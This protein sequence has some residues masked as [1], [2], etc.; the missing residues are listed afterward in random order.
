MISIEKALATV[1]ASVKP[2]K[3]ER[4]EIAESLDRVLAEDIVA[5]DD[6]PPFSN[7]AMD[8]YAVKAADLK[9]ASRRSP[10]RLPV[11]EDIPAGRVGSLRIENGR[12]ARIMTGAPVPPGADAVVRVEETREA[13]GGAVEIS[14]PVRK[15]ENIRRA[16]ENVKK[17]E[18]V[19]KKGWTIRPQEIGMLAALGY[20]SVRVIR[21][22]RVA[23]ISTGDE[24]QA[25]TEKP[26]VGKIRD[27]NRYTLTALVARY[28]GIP[29]PLGIVPDREREL[30]AKFKKALACDLFVTSGGVSVGKYDF[31]KKVMGEICS[32]VKVWQVAM[33]PGK[34]LS[35]GLMK[36]KPV[37]GLP[38]NPVSVMVS[39]LQF[40]RPALLKM[41]GKKK[42]RKPNVRATLSKD[43]R[44]KTDRTHLVRAIVKKVGGKYYARPSGPQGSGILRSLVLANAL[45]IIPPNRGPVRKG[46]R[47]RAILIDEAEE[48]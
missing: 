38:G 25:I 37:F 34:P 3:S 26:V 27:C 9:S 20:S 29:V 12:A 7:S 31:V 43:C 28:G 46:E 14:A 1:L 48:D 24:V 6:I 40:V 36:G 4:V 15:R 13:E 41:E 19:L 44:E 39:F 35:F 18:L 5:R 47:V 32:T 30:K 2:L 21:R 16:G 10:C 11:V 22:P 23:I 17:G 8:G 42:L 33:K 45:L